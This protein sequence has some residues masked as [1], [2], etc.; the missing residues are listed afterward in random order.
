MKVNKE[1]VRAGLAGRQNSEGSKS[2]PDW[3]LKQKAEMGNLKVQAGVAVR[4]GEGVKRL[5]WWDALT[6]GER[7][8]ICNVMRMLRGAKQS[9]LRDVAIAAAKWERGI[10]CFIKVRLVGENR[11]AVSKK[12]KWI[13]SAQSRQGAVCI[14]LNKS[15][16]SP[17]N[18]R[19][20]PNASPNQN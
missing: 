12:Q 19:S 15:T 18:V 7:K 13:G 5:E 4:G 3:Q 20:L 11:K 10:G 6:L 2:E 9:E 16:S 17:T 8:L 1:E 14:T